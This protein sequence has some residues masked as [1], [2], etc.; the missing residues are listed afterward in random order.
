LLKKWASPSVPV[1]SQLPNATVVYQ[2]P[3]EVLATREIAQG[4]KQVSQ[5]LMKWSNMEWD[6]ATWE[7]EKQLRQ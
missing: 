2:V 4:T 3:E 1:A 6:L 5:V 7:N